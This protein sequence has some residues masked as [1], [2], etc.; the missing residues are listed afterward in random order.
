MALEE[1]PREDL[2]REATA[3]VRRGVWNGRITD[4]AANVEIVAGF[5]R[6]GALSLFFDESP[7]YQFNPAGELRRAHI[8]GLLYK[9]DRGQLV[10]MRRERA[11]RQT[12]LVSRPLTDEE[13]AALMVEAEA[14]ISALFQT[15]DEGQLSLVGQVPED[16]DLRAELLAWRDRY[17][18]PL[19]IADRPNAAG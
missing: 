4:S 17:P 14:R 12:T 11:E 9:A 18:L 1:E 13:Q 16:G 19:Q 7:V 10:Q 15:L 8:D 2:L 5:R 6:N 3:L